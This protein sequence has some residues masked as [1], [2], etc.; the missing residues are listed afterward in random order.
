MRPRGFTMLELLAVI[1]IIGLLA[2]YVAPRYFPEVG[3]SEIAAAKARI[4]SGNR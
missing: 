1:M 4:E 3:K 2:G